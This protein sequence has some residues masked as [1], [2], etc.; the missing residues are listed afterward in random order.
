MQLGKI[1][2]QNY[3][4]FQLAPQ[5]EKQTSATA[6]FESI[7]YMILWVYISQV[8]LKYYSVITN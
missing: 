2:K 6:A 3:A 5:K 4:I 7:I 1:S 8:H